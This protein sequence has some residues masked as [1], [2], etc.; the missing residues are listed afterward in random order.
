VSEISNLRK[1]LQALET[2]NEGLRLLVARFE[3]DPS[4]HAGPDEHQIDS[5]QRR[6]DDLER[7]NDRLTEDAQR[8]FDARKEAERMANCYFMT[9]RHWKARH[10]ELVIEVKDYQNRL[11]TLVRTE[12]ELSSTQ[13]S[14]KSCEAELLELKARWDREKNL[15]RDNSKPSA[16]ISKRFKQ[17]ELE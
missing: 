11:K 13:A 1:K 7:A 6:I 10:D 15:G 2:E 16:V 8:H 3:E 5:M 14:L 9:E 17:L 4:R 12:L